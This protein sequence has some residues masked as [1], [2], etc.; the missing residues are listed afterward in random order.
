ML[1]THQDKEILYLLDANVL[2]DADRNY[3]QMNKVPEFWEW[4]VHCAEKGT[5]K[6]PF[7]IYT[8]ILKGE[9]ALSKWIT[10]HKESLIIERVIKPK[11]IDDIIHA[12]YDC[13]PKK[14][15]DIVKLGADPFL[16]AYA[17]MLQLEDKGVCI[18]SNEAS[19][20]R[21]QGAN[22]KIPDIAKKM[23]IPCGD[24]FYLNDG[25]DFSTQWKSR[26]P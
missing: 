14:D 15:T 25:L 13:D 3:Y 4:L 9:D 19:K 26:M 23:N 10:E 12:G 22:Q 7:E 8:E 20:P 11:H 1:S 21:R 6:I 16:L 24:I 2:I 5:I 18:I 17:Y